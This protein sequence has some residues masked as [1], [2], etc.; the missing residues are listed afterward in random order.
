[1]HELIWLIL[2]LPNRA[3]NPNCRVQ[4]FMR[5]AAARKQ[6]RLTKE[7]IEAQGCETLPWEKCEVSA[8][9]YYKTNRR[10]DQD[11][12]VAALKSMYD[13]IVDAGLVTDDTKEHMIR[14]WPEF[15]QDKQ[16][17]RMEVVIRRASDD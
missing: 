6:R 13:G 9:L 7:A 5:R 12:T 8:T 14:T 15:G 4:P 16:N 2:P 1:M 3:L 17:P 10:R 11:N